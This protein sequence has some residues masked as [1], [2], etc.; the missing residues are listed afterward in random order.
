MPAALIR[1]S[2]VLIAALAL[3]PGAGAAQAA[4]ANLAGTWLFSVT[5]D[6]G[7]GTPTVTLTQTGDSI[8]GGYASETF[9]QQTVRGKITNREF[10]MQFTADVAGQSLTVVYR[11][12]IESATALKGTVNLG[13]LGTGTFTAT[14]RPAPG[15]VAS[16]RR[17]RDWI[18]ER[19]HRT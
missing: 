12:T 9:G 13:G 10:T 1:I 14:K 19:A 7:T 16:V 6:A 5:T 4:P 18:G 3:H 8:S 11:G 17:L 2:L 15:A